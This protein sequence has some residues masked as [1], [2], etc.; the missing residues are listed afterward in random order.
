VWQD[1]VGDE[2]AHGVPDQPF[3]VVEQGVDVEE[4]ARAKPGRRAG[5]VSRCRCSRLG[6]HE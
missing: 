6:A 2:A 3:L 4:V 5:G 1:P